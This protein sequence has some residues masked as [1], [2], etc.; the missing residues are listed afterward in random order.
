MSCQGHESTELAGLGNV[1]VEKMSRANT[2][3]R[4]C[5]SM[6]LL[7][8]FLLLLILFHTMCLMC[9]LIEIIFV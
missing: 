3:H 7:P 5:V 8:I 2:L 9:T 6:S 1:G 4:K